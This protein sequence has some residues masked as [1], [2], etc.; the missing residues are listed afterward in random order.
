M[1]M[2]QIKGG[3]VAF[4]TNITLPLLFQNGSV[5]FARTL[6]QR[7]Q[8]YVKKESQTDWGKRA[9][10]KATDS[11]IPC[12]RQARK[13]GI[14]V[15][16][17]SRSYNGAE[18]RL[19][20]ALKD[21]PRKDVF[22][23]TKIDDRSQFLG[24]VEECFAESLLQLDTDYVDLLLL[25]WPV[26]Y[27]KTGDKRFDGSVPIFARSWRVLEEIYKSGRAKAIG[28]ANFNITH[29]E[30]LKKYAD[31][32]PMADEFECHPLCIRKE[33]NDYCFEQGIQVFAYASLC[34][35]DP[36]L[37]NEEMGR[38]AEAHNKTIAQVILKWH[39]QNGR[40]P[41]FG[42][43]RTERI[44]EYAHLGDFSLTE[45][46]LAVIDSQ[47]IN[48]RAFPDSEHC[49]FTKGIWSGWESYKDCC[50]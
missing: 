19:A 12:V 28:V 3:S 13:E 8:I 26:D 41:I 45:K 44:H 1:E 34:A 6:L 9:T 5:G 43:S 21:T 18:Q 10:L 35:M 14:H 47:N 40:I 29:L 15:F 42:T 30:Q 25:H 11:L 46:E 16:D 23:I 33:L 22:F 39:M 20:R 24:R 36:R 38:I 48:Y 4:G 27:P 31:I 2:S 17:C 49:D 50:P 37:R 7:V 32:M